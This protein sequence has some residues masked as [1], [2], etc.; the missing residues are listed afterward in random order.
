[1][2]GKKSFSNKKYLLEFAVRHAYLYICIYAYDMLM[3]HEEK[4][5]KKQNDK[6]L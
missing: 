3:F 1:M 5:K 2:I 4:N 6:K